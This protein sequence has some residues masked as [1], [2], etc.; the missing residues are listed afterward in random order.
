MLTK[1]DLSSRIEEM[2]NVTIFAPSNRA[3]EKM[4]ETARRQLGTSAGSMTDALSYLT[5]QPAVMLSDF[6]DNLEMSSALPGFSLR[7]NIYETVSPR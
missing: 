2:K 6:K 5:V 3:V 1:T 7:M 4:T